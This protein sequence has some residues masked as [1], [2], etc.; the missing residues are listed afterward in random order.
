VPAPARW[1]T[2]YDH[3]SV[4]SRA[5]AMPPHDHSCCR[6]CAA[7][8]RGPPLRRHL[9]AVTLRYV[10]AGWL[11]GWLARRDVYIEQPALGSPGVVLGNTS[12]PMRGV[13]FERVRVRYTDGKPHPVQPSKHAPL[14]NTYEC[15]AVHGCAIGCDPPPPC[16]AVVSPG[17]PLPPECSPF[18]Q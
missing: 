3:Q 4:T 7:C 9:L 14:S 15:K 10:A 6:P 2:A 12:R 18:T 1:G 16:F 17:L 13:V 11:A 8:T 5:M